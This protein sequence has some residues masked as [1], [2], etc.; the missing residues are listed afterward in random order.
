MKL[1]RD[2]QKAISPEPVPGCGKQCGFVVL[3]IK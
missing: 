2:C 3:T 1:E